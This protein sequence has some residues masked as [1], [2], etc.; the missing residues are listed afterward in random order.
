MENNK[1]TAWHHTQNKNSKKI[2]AAVPSQHKIRYSNP[3]L[4]AYLELKMHLER[5]L[6][7]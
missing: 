7:V 3:L 5:V 6:K 1:N 4:S 2:S